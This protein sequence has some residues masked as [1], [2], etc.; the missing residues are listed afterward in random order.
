MKIFFIE[1]YIMKLIWKES[2]PT[3]GASVQSLVW[4]EAFNALKHEVFL[5][6]LEEDNYPI[7]TKYIW[8]KLKPLFNS[9]KKIF[10][11]WFIY[12][13]PK[14]FKVIKDTNPDYI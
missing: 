13:F 8:I 14:I 12:R 6:K 7:N 1:K 3:G 10:A 4:M 5:A 2:K 11:V 9:N